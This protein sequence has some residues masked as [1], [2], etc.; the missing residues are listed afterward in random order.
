MLN[1]RKPKTENR[2][3]MPA[4]WEPHAATLLAWPHETTDWPGKLSTIRW[5]YV[6]IVKHLHL[7]EQVVVL[8]NDL[9]QQEQASR[10]LHR[11]SVDLQ[12]VLFFRIP[13]NRSW[14]RD[15]GPIGVVHNKRICFTDWR[16]NGW[17][18]YNNW[19]RDDA[20]PARLART[21]KVRRIIPRSHNARIVL[22]GGSIDVNG[23]GTLLTT[24]QCLLSP[25]QARNPNLDR[26]ELEVA[27]AGYLGA[28][29]IL[30]L[31]DGIVG[32][33]THG[34]VDDVAR[35]VDPRTV[36]V[37]LESDRGDVNYAPTQEN[38][39]RLK[40]M[41]DQSGRRLR[42]VAL[43]LPAPLIFDGTRLPASYV[44]FYIANKVVI[45]P[46]FNDPADRIALNTLE[47]LFPRRTV[48]GI[49]S[50][51]LVQGLGALHC[52]TQQIPRE[53]SRTTAKAQRE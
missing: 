21:L 43:P 48:V 16:F 52:L 25:T 6:E 2:Y 27:F 51:D 46:T 45:V 34:H 47:R 38:Y 11:G 31:A 22:E 37:A 18:K 26:R 10:A 39:R 42:A 13:T 4:E 1:T 49:H 15:T 30:W 5:V 36:V 29:N 17:A 41:R 23:H 3:R 7:N 32:D 9:K 28:H 33:D 12:R 19:R 35:F 8:V 40:T 24:E 53:V 14:M 44:N 50:V 20:I